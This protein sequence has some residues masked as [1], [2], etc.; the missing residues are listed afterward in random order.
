MPSVEV[1]RKRRYVGLGRTD[2]HGLRTLIARLASGD[3]AAVDATVHRVTDT[4]PS[5]VEEPDEG[6]PRNPD[7]PRP[8]AMPADLLTLLLEHTDSDTTEETPPSLVEEPDEGGPRNPDLPRPLAM[9]ADLLD[10][11]RQVDL[12]AL[13]P[14]A[15]L[16]VHLHEA[17]LHGRAGVARVE[18]L[19]PHTLDQ[20][21]GLLARTD[22]RIQPV[23]DLS[24]RTRYTAYEHPESLRDQVHLITG[25]DY[26]P[27]ATSTSRRVD[28]D[29]PTPY[30]PAGPPG[31]TGPHNAGPLGR[32]HHRW[33]THAGYRSR[34]CGEGRYVW[35]TPH[36]LAFLTDH[37][38]THRIPREQAEMIYDA[39]PGV[40]IYPT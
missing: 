24:S 2:E 37:R 7:L 16:H 6:G 5:L 30:D 34:Q 21:T 14:K 35:L 10:T 27:Y 25:G 36:G 17:S 23:K 26:W 39:P 31:Q 3:A 40:D 19:G 8:L 13:R 4:P 18:G 11:L 29:H 38:G 32:R 12:S 15:V 22:L 33:K 20:L 9:P 28:L 1:E